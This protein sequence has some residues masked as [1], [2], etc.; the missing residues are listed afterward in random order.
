M[1]NLLPRQQLTHISLDLQVN[2]YGILGMLI[3][4]LYGM[5]RY[6]HLHEA[7]TYYA[8]IINH[9]VIYCFVSFTVLTVLSITSVQLHPPALHL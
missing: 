8:I 1:D 6:L 4:K 3:K 7:V 5:S 9:Y 2:I